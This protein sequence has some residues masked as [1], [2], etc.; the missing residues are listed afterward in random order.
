MIR[1]IFLHGATAALLAATV[2]TPFFSRAE[3]AELDQA[4]MRV[5]T[6]WAAIQ[7]QTPQEQREARFEALAR[8]AHSLVQQYNDRAEAHIW[9]GIVL[10]SWAG[11]KGGLGALGIAERAKAE[12]ESAIRIDRKALS[13]SALNSLG[14][15]YYK[16]PGWPVGFGDNKKA[17]S[18]LQQALAL[19]PDGIDPNYF[20]ADYLVYRNRKAEAV[21][22]LEKALRAPARPGREV[23]DQGRR[24]EAGALLRQIRS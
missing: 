4:I 7:Y 5:Q 12:Y 9:E 6:E 15:L 23:A 10:S 13:G 3:P 19:N 20:Y 11:A 17:E 18:L 24:D 22:Y 2:G 14:V 21:P 8:Q 1:R 16:V